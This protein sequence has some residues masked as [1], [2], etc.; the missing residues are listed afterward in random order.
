MAFGKSKTP[1]AGAPVT[2]ITDWQVKSALSYE[3]VTLALS[4]FENPFTTSDKLGTYD[5][6]VA[7]GVVHFET[8]TDRNIRAD[9]TFL[10]DIRDVRPGSIGGAYVH[11][12]GTS[13]EPYVVFSIEIV[14]PRR[15]LATQLQ[16]AFRSAA[17]SNNR[18]VH[19]T[20]NRTKI[21]EVPAVMIE[22]G[23]GNGNGYHSISQMFI[24][25][26]IILPQ[27]PAWSWAWRNQ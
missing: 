19:V 2:D 22:L 9:V 21:K 10:D 11:M 3:W 27:A 26:Q 1:T 16:E 14:D 24:R 7:T 6:P 15:K 20:F 13:E 17:V 12:A 5:S 25:H 4:K 23:G 18:F 8:G